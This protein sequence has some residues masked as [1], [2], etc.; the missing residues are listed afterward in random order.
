MPACQD[1]LSPAHL[2][3]LASA[4]ID[5]KK[6]AFRPLSLAIQSWKKNS[7]WGPRAGFIIYIYIYVTLEVNKLALPGFRHSV[8]WWGLP[9]RLDWALAPDRGAGGYQTGSLAVRMAFGRLRRP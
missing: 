6:N 9:T 7:V 2:P 1:F 3:R 8:D 5:I 4:S